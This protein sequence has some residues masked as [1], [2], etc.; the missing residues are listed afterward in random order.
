MIWGYH[1]FWKH[2]YVLQ[3]IRPE[4]FRWNP[5]QFTY[6]LHRGPR[7][8]HL[9]IPSL[10]FPASRC[11]HPMSHQGAIDRPCHVTR[12]G[13]RFETGDVV[14]PVVGNYIR[15]K[16]WMKQA[17][18]T[19]TWVSTEIWCDITMIRRC[20][21]SGQHRN[22]STHP[23]QTK[24]IPGNGWLWYA[25]NSSCFVRFCFAVCS[26]GCKLNRGMYWYLEIHCSLLTDA[27]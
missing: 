7:G 24:T 21:S 23:L 4:V 9:N 5:L 12:G 8:P 25:T 10:C 13:S 20:F 2:P 3:E 19:P 6:H 15:Q 16:H 22:L 17:P 1:Y 26:S 18:P 11:Q 14:A 27:R